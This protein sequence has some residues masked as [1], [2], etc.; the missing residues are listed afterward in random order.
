MSLPYSFLK[1]KVSRKKHKVSIFL[2]ISVHFKQKI[3]IQWKRNWFLLPLL[4]RSIVIWSALA[5][6][7]LSEQI[8]KSW[9]SFNSACPCNITGGAKDNMDTVLVVYKVTDIHLAE[10]KLIATLPGSHWWADFC[11]LPFH[12]QN[13]MF[14]LLVSWI[15]YGRYTHPNL[16]NKFL[17]VSFR[18]RADWSR[19]DNIWKRYILNTAG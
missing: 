8:L 15:Q 17:S 4:F 9:V 5:G 12:T 2:K 11:Q 3:N 16:R 1:Y 10:I 13:L 6:R 7:M 19:E 18:W 14:S